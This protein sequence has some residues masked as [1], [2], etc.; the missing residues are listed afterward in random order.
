MVQ[1]VV[2]RGGMRH[3]GGAQK[4]R[5]LNVLAV[6]SVRTG[7]L[8]QPPLL[9]TEKGFTQHSK[10]KHTKPLSKSLHTRHQHLPR[11]PADRRC[12]GR[13]CIQRPLQRVRAPRPRDGR[14]GEPVGGGRGDQ[15]CD[16]AA[17]I[18]SGLL[19]WR[20]VQQHP[21]PH[22]GKRRRPHARG[23]GHARVCQGEGGGQDG[24][25]P[26]GGPP[27]TV[28]NRYRHVSCEPW[29]LCH[30]HSGQQSSCDQGGSLPLGRGGAAAA[31]VARGGARGGRGRAGGPKVDRQAAVGGEGVPTVGV[32]RAVA[33]GWVGWRWEG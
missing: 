30:P 17:S 9:P 8:R 6:V 24:G 23:H 28:D 29:K 15:G 10:T 31:A 16:E 26:V 27:A 33:V 20:R 18:R 5:T 7:Q 13:R 21:P 4:K 12:S 3:R 25:Y 2:L 11:Q 32:A 14:L 22:P 1:C 19:C